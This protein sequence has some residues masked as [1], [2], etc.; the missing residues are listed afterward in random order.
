MMRKTIEHRRLAEAKGGKK[1]PR[2][3]AST[4]SVCHPQ[5]HRPRARTLA[6]L[7]MPPLPTVNHKG[8]RMN[9]LK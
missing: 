5:S 1:I 3:S 9:L 4:D 7:P 8:A 2:R 6:A